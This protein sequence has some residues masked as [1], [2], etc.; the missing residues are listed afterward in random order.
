MATCCLRLPNLFFGSDPLFAKG[1]CGRNCISLSYLLSSL[2]HDL[3]LQ[4]I[5]VQL[6][7]FPCLQAP[8]VQDVAPPLSVRLLQVVAA[9]PPPPKQAS[10]QPDRCRRRWT[11]VKGSDLIA[12]K[13]RDSLRLRLRFL[14]LHAK[15]H[16]FLRP[17]D[18]RGVEGVTERGGER[19]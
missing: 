16:D 2:L 9:K 10:F 1:F 8:Y 5:A 4:A 6:F 12:P 13:S 17:Q 14:P 15:S 11:W 7:G 18:R 3:P 19:F